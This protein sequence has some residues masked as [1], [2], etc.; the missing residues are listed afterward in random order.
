MDN[1]L[2]HALSRTRRRHTRVS[3]RAA[4][5]INH[6]WPVAALA[7][8][9]KAQCPCGRACTEPHLASDPVTS[10]AEAAQVWAPG[11][12]WDIALITT[13]FDVVDLSPEYGALLHHRLITSCPTAS[14]PRNR[15]WHFVVEHNS[16]PAKPVAASGGVVHSGA[17]GWI[18]TSP[19]RTEATG[20]IGWVVHPQ[21][22][23]WRPYRRSDLVDQLFSDVPK[24][25]DDPGDESTG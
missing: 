16:F 14:A 9:T 23:Q 17:D 24:N 2:V 12:R 4:E 19:T 22:T 13:W 1:L 15:R 8:P 10:R 25:D 6:G 5:C 18:A 7:V 11:H 21:Y 3:A 20:R